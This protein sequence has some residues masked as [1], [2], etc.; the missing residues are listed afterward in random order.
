M[1]PPAGRHLR[2]HAAVPGLKEHKDAHCRAFVFGSTSSENDL[3]PAGAPPEPRV[4]ALCPAR[5]APAQGS[6]SSPSSS[7]AVRQRLQIS[8]YNELQLP[9]GCVGPSSAPPSTST[10]RLHLHGELGS[11]SPPPPPPPPPAPP[12]SSVTTPDGIAIESYKDAGAA[13]AR[14][15]GSSPPMA[16]W[17]SVGWPR[18]APTMPSRQTGVA[19]PPR[20]ARQSLTAEQ[21]RLATDAVWAAAPVPARRRSAL[22]HPPSPAKPPAARSLIARL[23]GPEHL[24]EV[25][26]WGLLEPAS[27]DAVRSAQAVI[28][29]ARAAAA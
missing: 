14:A 11:S 28:A 10:G 17:A 27:A 3:G 25:G 26:G 5:D 29:A 18:T 21:R 19:P 15:D 16:V 6:V 12:R 23:G 24:P 9:E 4:L 7:C 13:P 20:P 8:L 22:P 2:S 1:R